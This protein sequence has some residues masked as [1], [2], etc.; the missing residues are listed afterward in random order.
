MISC[1]FWLILYL[2]V[3]SC[4]CLS[5]D[6]AFTSSGSL[7]HL[8]FFQQKVIANPEQ[9]F[10]FALTYRN[11]TVLFAIRKHDPALSEEESFIRKSVGSSNSPL[12]CSFVG[13]NPDCLATSRRCR[14]LELEYLARF[15][16]TISPAQLALS[17]AD[18]AHR[19][20]MSGSER[21][22]ACNTLIIGCSY[23][24]S[25]NGIYK[26]D[27]TGNFWKC[28]AAGIG[29]FAPEFEDWVSRR[30]VEIVASST[31]EEEKREERKTEEGSSEEEEEFALGLGWTALCEVV[32][33]ALPNFCI[34]MAALQRREMR[35]YSIYSI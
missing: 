15:E 24:G 8:E 18:D 27:V 19:R 22:W 13:W 29:G 1:S 28:Q 31:I 35:G 25:M 14:E 32:G 26:V 4:T 30:G 23:K 20:S 5:N 11:T 34:E 33:E 17:L 21:P 16:E 12:L 7:K 10:S 6:Y 9:A 3:F 2:A